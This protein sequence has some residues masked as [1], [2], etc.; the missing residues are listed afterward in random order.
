MNAMVQGYLKTY[1]AVVG[2]RRA[3]YI[4]KVRQSTY[5]PRA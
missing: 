1:D 3:D 2:E 5:N 4:E